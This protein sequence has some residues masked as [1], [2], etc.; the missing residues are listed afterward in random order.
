MTLAIWLHRVR[1]IREG[2]RRK[3]TARRLRL[4][5]FED[6]TMPSTFIITSTGDN[7][8][9]N[10]SPGAG[11]GTLRQAI[12]DADAVGTGTGANPD[13][14]AFNIPT[15]DPG[16]NS[17]T[18]AFTI[19]PLSALPTVS[20]TVV[21]DGFT[22]PGSAPNTLPNQGPGAGDNAMRNIIVD[23]SL[24]SGSCNLGL[25]STPDQARAAL[26]A[27]AAAAPNGLVVAGGNSKVTGLVAQN[28]RSDFI[29]YN[30]NPYTG[31]YSSWQIA[32]GGT[33]IDLVSNANTVAGVYVANAGPGILVD[34]A[35]NNA[36]GGTAPGARNVIDGSS[37]LTI[38]GAG[39][40]GNRVQGSYIGLDG[41]HV[42]NS[43]GGINIVNASDNVIGG[44][45][46]GAGNVIVSGNTGIWIEGD[47]NSTPASGNVVQGNYIGTN[48][49]GDACLLPAGVRGGVILL[50]YENNTTIGGVDTNTPGAPLAGGGNLISGW[51]TQVNLDWTGPF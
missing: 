15:T 14:I 26:D 8:G 29:A 51:R 21:I 12:V 45:A 42:L 44:A 32:I 38:Q 16:Y 39:A 43:D 40:T 31:S 24:L 11:T 3:S 30:F 28:W 36:I 13:L 6:R 41:T 47:S 4:G 17:T 19:Q 34:N 20:D 49:A 5:I 1:A 35:A 46:P 9:V 10:P 25:Y 18:G 23:G 48:P 22:Q 33:G 37:A 7:G 2:K 27:A 50:G